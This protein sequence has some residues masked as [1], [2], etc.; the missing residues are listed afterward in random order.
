[1]EFKPFDSISEKHPSYPDKQQQNE[2]FTRI[3]AESDQRLRLAL[4]AAEVG[5]WDLDLVSYT[6][7]WDAKCKQL[8]GYHQHDFVPFEQVLN[9]IHPSDKDSVHKAV[10]EATN[11]EIRAPYNIIFRTI[12]ADDGQLRWLQCKGRAMFNERNEAVRFTGIAQDITIQQQQKLQLEASE[13]RYR[14]LIENS[15]VGKVVFTGRDMKVDII[16]DAM[17]EIWGKER[18]NVIGK[19]LLEAMPELE[20]QPF[21][22]QLQ[23]VYDTGIPYSTDKAVAYI[24]KKGAAPEPHWFN[25]N[26]RA[27]YDAE[28][29]IYGVINTAT[30]ISEVI[31][32]L[33][34]EKR[35]NE[36]LQFILE[37]GSLGTWYLDMASYQLFYDAK[38]Q[39]LVGY[40]PVGSISLDQ[41]LSYVYEPDK[42]KVSQAIR[43]AFDAGTSGGNFEVE[44][45]TK[46][47]AA[48]LRIKGRVKFDPAGNPVQ[49]AGIVMDIS[50]HKQLQKHKDDFISTASHEIKTPIT[51]IKTYGQLLEAH[52]EESGSSIEKSMVKKMNEQ[53]M[54]LNEL[55][56]GLLDVTKMQA[57]KLNYNETYFDFDELTN[58]V[59]EE[60]QLISDT[61]RIQKRLKAGCQVYGDKNRI[62]QVISNLITNAIKYSPGAKDIIVNTAVKGDEVTLCVEDFG[63]GISR[64]KQ[65]K[66]FEQFYQAGGEAHTFPGLGLGLYISSQI[67]RHTDGRIW[68]ENTE[69]GK[70]STFCFAL[71]CDYRNSEN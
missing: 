41:A 48:W 65:D 64:D 37:A 60:L 42:E 13:L 49:L 58:S 35:A 23:Q 18:E 38:T 71:P 24:S 11:P 47:G 25:Y 61:H 5:T 12:G 59:T 31:E 30:E 51:T 6:V 21:L 10:K 45:R 52:L 56:N 50:M 69:E 7:Y 28:G 62:R 4:E 34:A 46:S 32:A 55:V 16:N 22:A 68:I 66:V 53:V 36:E 17:L 39:A 19:T 44:Q 14:D 8:Y 20:G 2:Y 40:P 3:S 15:A 70:G 26:Y 27:L 33:H 1:M 57:G 43:H 9:C 63:I 54:R 67:I 29:K